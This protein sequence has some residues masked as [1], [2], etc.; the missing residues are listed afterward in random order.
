[1]PEAA[2]QVR[3]QLRYKICYS[4]KEELQTTD[5]IIVADVKKFIRRSAATTYVS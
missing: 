3:R 5:R 4:K 1:L 2:K